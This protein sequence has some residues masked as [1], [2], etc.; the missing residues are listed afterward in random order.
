MLSIRGILSFSRLLLMV[1]ILPLP[2]AAGAE[3]LAPGG[4]RTGWPV[5]GGDSAGTRYSRLMQIS[6][7]NVADLKVAWTY[8]TGEMARRGKK[9]PLS[10]DQDTPITVA[11]NLI[12]CTP[13]NRLIA[14]DPATGAER[15]VY[16]P[17]V[18]MDF[19]SPATYACRGVAAWRDD[20]VP[21]GSAC[22]D[23]LF[24]NT[25]D[26]RLIA[27]DARTGETCTAFGDNGVIS[28]LASREQVFRGEIRYISPPTL[29]N[30]VVVIGS[31]I[32][33]NYRVGTPSG[34]VQAFDARSGRKL[35]EFDPIPH[36]ADDPARATWGGG[37]EVTGSANVW[38]SMAADEARDLVFLPT[39]SPA[40]DYYGGLRPGNNDYADSLVALRGATGEVVWHYQIVHHDI[41][42]YDIGSQPL[43]TDLTLDG[44][45]VPAVVQN[46]KQGLVFVFNRE[47]GEP[48]FPIEE[49][50]VPAGDVP[51]EWYS[52]TQP[53]PAVFP[54]LV[55]QEFSP[56]D[57]WGFTFWDRNK[58][59]DQAENLLTG[60]IYTPPHLGQGTVKVPWS[61][62]GANWGGAALDPGT[63]TMVINTNR[64][65]EV[66]E[67][68]PITNV[69]KPEVDKVN[70]NEP[71]LHAPTRMEGTPY[72]VRISFFL[73]PLGAPCTPPP[74]GGLTA[75]DL[76]N[77][78][79]LWDVPLGSI[80][81]QIPV[82]MPF[83]I[84]LGTP[85][86]GGPIVTGGGLVFIAATVDRRLRAFDLAT[87]KE[88]WSDKLPADAQ[89][90]PITYEVDGRQYVV[91]VAGGH[92]QL[93]NH[94]GDFVIAYALPH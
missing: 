3:Q 49:R 54:P 71:E 35:W 32:L 5:H 63:K 45:T 22:H 52:P 11:G 44:K 75:V 38:A 78:K 50:S 4:V 58:C 19:E 6:P 43:L 82:P 57:A 93:H 46:T 18:D 62:G 12:V 23:R 14:L 77:A 16:D 74:W 67:L 26:L 24:M 76:E 30:G 33:D 84:R 88:L 64:I 79:I 56:E 42:D 28:A 94:R 2:S 29:I 39:S 86:L 48:L 51:G 37:D 40:P 72:G 60:K 7:V 73:S 83:Q 47:T 36:R 68:V 10:K 1:L 87:G 89:A 17:Q 92:G 13:F 90:T 59:R 15:W 53:I 31:A 55:P 91:I 9:F 69:R 70:G 20:A 8:R 61:G 41:W 80:Q 34:K 21:V 81:D 85:N 66:I 65:A 27:I 25:N